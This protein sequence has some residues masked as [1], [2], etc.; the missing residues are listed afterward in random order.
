MCKCRAIA[1]L[2]I[3][4][5]LFTVVHAQTSP[6]FI[7][8]LSTTEGLSS[9]KINDI[10][11]DDDGFLWV[12]TSDGLN[13][14]DGTEVIQYYHQPGSNSIPHNYIFCLEKLPGNYIA[15]GTQAGLS[16]YNGNT[17]SFTNFY[18]HQDDQLDEYNNSIFKLETDKQGNLWAA[19]KNCIYIFDK[20]RILK[21]TISSPFTEAEIS[22]K[23]QRFV[24]KILPLNDGSALLYLYN[25][26]NICT[27]ANYTLIPLDRSNYSARFMYLLETRK[28]CSLNQSEQDFPAATL[29]SLFDHFFLY[30]RPCTDSLLLYND[31]G[32]LLSRCYFPYNRYPYISWSQVVSVID[33]GNIQVS[34]HNYGIATVDI[35]WQQAHPVLEKVSASLFETS[36]YGNALEDRQGN[37][38]LAT[39][40][41][42]LQKISPHKQFFNNSTALVSH[43]TGKP[44][45][46]EVACFTG[47]NN[48]LYVGTYGEGFFEIDQRG[49][50]VQRDLAV[51][52]HNPWSNFIWNIRQVSADSLWIGTQAGLYWYS[53]SKNTCGRIPAWTGKPAMLDSVAITKQFTDSRGLVWMGL[54][55]GNGVC[56]VDPRAKRF[57]Y[58]PGNSTNGYPLRYPLDITEDKMGNI[59]FVNDASS[60]LVKWERDKHQFMLVALPAALQKQSGNLTAISYESDTAL[61][62]GSATDGLIK[63]NPIANH[64]TIYGHDR[65]LINSHIINIFRENN[66]R[67]WVIT[68]GGISLLDIRSGY[69]TNYTAKEGLPVQYPTSRFYFDPLQKKLYNGG[70]GVFFY[71]HPDSI[72]NSQTALKTII[73]EVLVNGKPYDYKNEPAKFG[74]KQNDIT[75][76]FTAVDLSNGPA[77]RYEYKLLGEDSSWIMA[78][79]M[80]QINFSHLAPGRYTFLV[81]ASSNGTDWSHDVASL[82]FNIKT[83]FTKSAL[84]Y[85]LLLLAMGGLFYTMYR[86]RIRQLKRTELVRREISRNLHDEVGSTLTNISLSSLLL[87]KQLKKEGTANHLLERIYEDSQQVSESMREIVW[88]INPKIYTIGEAFPRMVRYASDLLEAKNIE[89][90]VDMKPEVEDLKL[91]MQ[92]RR[93]LYLVFKE[94]VNNLAKY[95]QA[96]KVMISF[97]KEGNA[98]GMKI[99]DNGKGFNS[100]KPHSGEGL[101]N[102]QERASSHNW[103][104]TIESIPGAGTTV[105]LKTRIA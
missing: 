45:K 67:L 18:S 5:V 38:W 21:K 80:R 75:I 23:R 97:Q 72:Y 25:G 55:K 88:S 6:Y 64:F 41:E 1:L 85:A 29:F 51:L 77:N 93:D 86:F 58:F 4:A 63:F 76:Q 37:W 8:R 20:N 61:W 92:E 87:Q 32:Q 17:R 39:T 90:G 102:M 68:D 10:V 36:E 34:F 96:T 98:L 9:N 105:T 60:T 24:E 50:Q 3:C 43:V 53:L 91:S 42:G 65:G 22:R 52:T 2:F 33:S 47:F 73:T 14:F 99:S 101:K 103:N 69:F 84:F 62:L 81:R 49:Q 35:S 56:Y 78:G 30:I 44:V 74:A 19:S 16:F 13:R 54:G 46:Y 7:E 95:S 89:L 28:P 71:F 11:Q 15:I 26:W 94:A 57:E 83:P 48:T 40:E 104:L 70:K 66:Q 59:W 27:A 12:A 31:Q 79:N 100:T 82:S